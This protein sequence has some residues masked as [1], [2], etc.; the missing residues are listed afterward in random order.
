MARAIALAYPTNVKLLEGQIG[1]HDHVPAI[2]SARLLAIAAAA[3]TADHP[4]L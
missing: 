1:A 4:P 3:S 2:T